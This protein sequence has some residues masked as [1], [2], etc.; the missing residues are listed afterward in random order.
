MGY[1]QYSDHARAV[2]DGVPGAV[3]AAPGGQH[4]LERH[5]Q[6]LAQ[7]VGIPGNRAGQMLVELGGEDAPGASVSQTLTQVSDHLGV[8]EHLDR[9]A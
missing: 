2:I 3:V 7:P 5:V 1:R 6:R 9:L 8:G 4:L